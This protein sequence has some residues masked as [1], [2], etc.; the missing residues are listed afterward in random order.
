MTR[1]NSNSY[2]V[3]GVDDK[4]ADVKHGDVIELDDDVRCGYRGCKPDGLQKFNNTKI[5]V[6][7]MCI[8]AFSQGKLSSVL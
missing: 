5:L 2:H 6:L 1:I 4:G 7:V 8:F 3:N